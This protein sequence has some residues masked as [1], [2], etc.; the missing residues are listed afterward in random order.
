MGDRQVTANEADLRWLVGRCVPSFPMTPDDQAKANRMIDALDA[1]DAHR[2]DC[3]TT[4][5]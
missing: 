2:C 5:E 4:H 1:L 3:G